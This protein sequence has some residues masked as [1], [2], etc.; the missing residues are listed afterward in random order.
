[1]DKKKLIILISS[2]V[3]IL[4]LLLVGLFLVFSKDK[5]KP[6]E[7]PTEEVVK[8]E[9]LDKFKFEE[10]MK[11]NQSNVTDKEILEIEKQVEELEEDD[12]VEKEVLD[13]QSNNGSKV[14]SYGDV[15]ISFTPGGQS[16][17]VDK[18]K[19]ERKK[20]QDIIGLE[21]TEGEFKTEEFKKE[22]TTA[23]KSLVEKLPANL[24]YKTFENTTYIFDKNNKEKMVFSYLNDGSMMAK[25]GEWGFYL[26]KIYI[27]RSYLDKSQDN[28]LN[29]YEMV[30]NS[31]NKLTDE[32]LK[33]GIAIGNYNYSFSAGYVNLL[34]LY[35]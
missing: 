6:A 2:I 34:Y 22:V 17:D 30:R 15:K 18:I 7:K 11:Q 1:M 10:N 27:D 31:G 13:T 12:A 28:V 24:D 14:T 23:N 32:Q 8:E 3:L 21:D 25:K 9:D 33:E 20:R 35:F 16:A 26:S 4:L 29:T 19:E 5:E